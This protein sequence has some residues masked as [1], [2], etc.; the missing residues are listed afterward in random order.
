MSKWAG[1]QTVY[2]AFITIRKGF[3]GQDFTNYKRVCE[4][5]AYFLMD[6][7]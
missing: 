3:R 5:V 1:M 4:N 2:D 7:G 6:F